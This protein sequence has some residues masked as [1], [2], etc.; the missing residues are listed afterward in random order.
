MSE[1][2]RVT[3]RHT[4]DSREQRQL[5]H[6]NRLLDRTRN[7][8]RLMTDD[9]FLTVNVSE[10]LGALAEGAEEWGMEL[11]QPPE[12]N[13][14]KMAYWSRRI[15]QN[16]GALSA[17]SSM[18]LDMAHDELA[19]AARSYLGIPARAAGEPSHRQFIL[20]QLS[21]VSEEATGPEMTP[22]EVAAAMPLVTTLLEPAG[23]GTCPECE[24]GKHGNCGGAAL[25]TEDEIDLCACAVAKHRD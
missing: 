9:M 15:M 11:D 17:D 20:E 25:N 21:D 6:L 19:K 18:D 7:M 23:W 24:Q 14:E 22:E 13:V 10:V 4:E 3:P 8:T 1:T 2:P 16:D 5:E 12:G